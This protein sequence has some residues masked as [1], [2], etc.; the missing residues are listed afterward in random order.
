MEPTQM[1][2]SSAKFRG[3]TVGVVENAH[4]DVTIYNPF[5]PNNMQASI[6]LRWDGNEPIIVD[7]YILEVEDAVSTLLADSILDFNVQDEDYDGV[8]EEIEFYNLEE[9]ER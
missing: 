6:A 9:N 4:G 2:L 5:T 3:E 7:M 8:Y 1:R